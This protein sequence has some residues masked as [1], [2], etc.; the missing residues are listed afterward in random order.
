MPKSDRGTQDWGLAT[1]QSLIPPTYLEW[2]G[3]V[4]LARGAVTVIDRA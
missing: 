3:P 4:S 1:G 2:T